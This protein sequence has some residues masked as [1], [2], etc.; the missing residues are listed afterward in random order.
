MK[1]TLR[2]DPDPK[3]EF[4]YHQQ[5][6]IYHEPY[7]I[8]D[9]ETWEAVLTT[10]AVYQIDVNGVNAGDVILEEKGKGVFMIVD[11]GLLPEFQGKGVG[12]AV[13]NELMKIGKKLTAVT[14]EETL[15]FFLKCGFVVKRRIRDYYDRGIEGYDVVWADR[16]GNED[17]ERSTWSQVTPRSNAKGK[18]I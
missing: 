5:F 16:V 1:I 8:W 18:K 13:L 6:K 3:T 9:R 15:P 11:F 14:R 17:R 2:R 7:L 12:R 10:C 4:Y